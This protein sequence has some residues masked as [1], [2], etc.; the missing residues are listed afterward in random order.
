MIEKSSYSSS[1]S[2]DLSARWNYDVFLSFR[3]EDVR[4]TFVD[5]LYVALQ[6]KGIH[7]FKDDEKLEKGKS[8]GPDLIRAIEE[9]RIALIVFSKNYADSKWCLDEVV[10]IMECKNV[11]G[12]IVLPVFYDVD[13]MTVRKQKTSYGEAFSNHEARFKGSK[14]Q[15]WRAALEEAADLSGLDLSNTANAHEARFVKE[16]VEDIM[17]K[18]GSQRHA[19]NVKNLVGME[20]QMQ[21]VYKMLGVGSGGVHFVGILGMSGVGKTTL[22]RVIYDD[23]SSQFEGACFLH[24][25]RD[26]SAKQGLERLQEILLSEILFIKDL[27]INNVFEGVNMQKHRLRYKKVL[28]VLDDVDHIDHLDV[29]AG[30]REWFGP[31]SRIIITTKDKHLLVKH[32]VEK[33]YKMRTLNEEES[34]QLFKQY[35]FKKNRPTKKFERI[36]AEVIKYTAGLPLALK[37]LGSF[38]Y[39]R[40]L[41]EWRSEVE[42]LKQIPEDEIL[43]K[44]EPSF[45]GLNSNE[46]KIF[47]DIACFFTGKKKDSVTRILKSFEFSP[48]I[49]VKVLMEKSLISISEGRIIMHQLIQEMGWY[50]VRREASDYP[51]EYSRL[52]KSEDIS[53]ILARNMGT[54]KIE[55]ISL[56]LAKMYTDIS[57][58]LERNLGTNTIKGMSLNFTNVKEVN[59]SVTAFMQMTRLRFLKI[60]N[61]YVS[62][63]PDILPGELSWLS[64]HG[65]ASK[66]LPIN[67]QGERLVSLKLK[68]SR[69]IQLWKGSKVL[70]KLKYINLS[71]SHKLIRTPDFSGTPNLER[72]VLEECTSLIEINFSVGDLKK[73]LLLNL[74]NCVNLKSLPKSIGLENLEVLILSGCSKLKVFPEIEEEMNCLSELYL[75]ATALSEVPA[76]V[77][78]LSGVNLINL[79]SCKN[80]ESLP[81]SIVRLNCLKTL[82]VSKCSKLKKLPDELGL[83]VGLEGLHCD[84]T[85]IEMMPSTISLLKNLKHLTLRRCNALASQREDLGLAFSNLS[86]LCSLTML[87]IGNCSISD[88]GILCNLGFLPSL[89]ELNLGGNTFTNISAASISGLTRLKVLQLVGCSRL[90]HFPELPGAIEEVHA[91]ECTSLRSINQLAKYPTL[92]RLS[93]SECHQFHDASL[94][95]ALW[96]NMLKGL[97]VLRSDISICIPGSEIPKWFPNTKLGDNVTLTLPNNWY[98]DNFWGF[99]FCIVFEGMEWCALYDGYLQPSQGFSVMLKFKTSDGKEGSTRSVVGIKGGDTSIRNSD[100]TLLA[101]VPSR[102]FLTAYNHEDYC[103]NDWIEIVACST[104]LRKFENKAWGMRLVYLDDIIEAGEDVRKTFVD[105]LYVALQQKGINTFKDDEKLDRGNSISPDLLRAIEESRIA[106]IVFSKNYANSTW[107]LD[108]LTKIMECNKR[109]GQIVLPVFYDI[110][111]S[112]VRK[113]KHSYGEAFGKH[114]DRFNDDKLQ[115][116]RA[117]LEEAANLSGWDLPN[118][119][120]AHEARVIKQIVEDIMTKL[121][122]HT[123]ASSAEDLVGMELHLQKVY[124][125]LQVRSDEVRFLGI[126]GMG[127]V[128]KTTLAR[129]IYD[130]IRSQFEGACFL[131]EVGDRSSKQGLERLQE[132]L[133]SEIL[134][135]KE[136]RINNLYEGDNLQRKRLQCK[137]VLLVLDDVDHI[138]QLDA[139]AGKCELFGPGSRIIITTKDKHLLVKHEVEKIYRMKPL[140]EYES[141]RLFKQ[142]AFKKIYPAK[143]FDDLSA[144]VIKR[145]AG[146]PLA[147]KVLGSYLYGRDLAEWTSEVEWLEQIPENEILQKLERSFTKLNSVEKKLFL[148][149]ACFFTGKKKNAV[150]RILD[151][152]NFRSAI[153]IK[154]LMEKSL[155]TISEGRILM[156]QLIQEMGWHIVRREASND[157]KMYSRLWK[158]E[159]ISLVLERNLGTEKIEGISLNLTSKEQV[160]VS[161]AA[162]MQMTRLRFLKFRNA[163]VFQGPDFLPDELRWLDW[164]GYPSKSLP[165]SFQGEQLVSLKL[166]S[167]SIIQLWETYKV[168]GRLKCINLSYSQ[169]LIRT[170]D[171][172]GTPNLE[173]LVLEECTSL[174]EINFSV[175]D[176]GRLVLLNLKNCRNL[177]TLPESIQ[178]E[179]LE[180]F[181]L[182]GCFKLKSFPEIEGKMNCLTELYLGASALSELPAS[183]ENLSRVSVINLSY[184]KR[185]ESLPRSI[186]RLKFLK[187]LDVS[188]CSKLKNLPD[189]HLGYLIGLEEF[190]RTDTAIR[191]IPSSVSLLKNLKQ[192]SLRG[193]N[194]LGLQG[195]SSS[196]FSWIQEK[197]HWGED[198]RKTSVDHLYVALQLKGINT[199]KDDERLEKG[200]SISP[201][202]VRAIEESRIALI[203]FSKNYADS[204]WCLDELT[205]IME[206]NKQKEQIVL[207][208]FYDVDPSTVRKQKHS[209]GEAFGNHEDIFK[210]DDKVQKWRAALEEAANLSGWDLPNT[211]DAHEAKVINKILKDTMARLGGQRHASNAENLVGME[212]HMNKLYK[213]LGVE[214]GVVRFLGILGMSGVGSNMQKQ[215][216]RYKKVLLVL[217]EVDHTDQL[218]A[219]AGEREWFGPGSRVIIT[220]KNKHLLVKYEGTEKIEGMSLHLTTEEQVNVSHTAFVQMARLRFLKFQNAYVCQGPDFLPDELRW[221]DWHG[222]PSKRSLKYLNLGH[223]QKLI[224]TPDFSGTPNLERLVLEECTSLVEFKFSVGD[225]G[226]LVLLNLANCRNLKTLP[227]S[228]RLGKLEILILS[229]CS[230]LKTFPEIDGKMHSL[231]ELYLGATAISELPASIENLSGVSVINLSYC[232]HL[233]SLPSSIFRLKYMKTL[234]VSGC[235]KLENLPDDLGHLVGLEELHCTHTAIQKIPSSMTLLKNLKHLALRGCNA[236]GSQVSS[237]SHAQKS[238]GVN[239]QNLS[240]LSS[241]ITLYVSDCNISDGGIL[242]DLGFLQSL[243]ELNLDGNNFSNIPAASISRLTQLKVLALA[244]CRRLESFPELPP[245]IEELF[246]DECTSLMSID[247]LT[248]YPML[249]EGSYKKFDR[250]GMFVPGVEIPEWFTY[251][252]WGTDRISVALPKNWYTPTFTGFAICVVFDMITSHFIISPKHLKMFQGPVMKFTFTSHDGARSGVSFLLGRIGSEKPLGLDNTFLGYLPI[253]SVRTGYLCGDRYN[254]VRDWIQLDFGTCYKPEEAIKGLGVPLVNKYDICDPE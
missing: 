77:E 11:K 81:K 188:G 58:A 103:P 122:V 104:A 151:S 2:P 222:Y 202:L 166:K 83:L 176:L 67:F 167:S 229:G 143:D 250:F 153:G 174:V 252:N 171:F 62:Q 54:E 1:T 244:D 157:P 14:V 73:L 129:V 211:A 26:R 41:V 45:T 38:L 130:N 190:H 237:S 69:I 212:S 172:S 179:K 49:G 18:L 97:Y 209:Y 75:E 198:V 239:F 134:V 217:D 36:S 168:L 116:W 13:A 48:V 3:G 32:D 144:Q 118:T 57:Q 99:A 84:D 128:G 125:M 56:N 139:L 63:G 238:M 162:F 20:S 46:Q 23:I 197:S 50:I 146:L 251:K 65:Y 35:A 66:S 210:L 200:K 234:D 236:L 226:K 169:K 95:D 96:S 12:Q 164:H 219:L 220:T 51:R 102:H 25:V 247:Q 241:L 208:V 141:F 123:H 185:L 165:I 88:G 79:S 227:K 9:S 61:A 184:C 204:T 70:G 109:K 22:A 100:H 160:K 177:K 161:R 192:L 21:K 213:M 228:F 68:N 33:M 189:D 138:D 72:L 5:H 71:H 249:R 254:R 10:K 187:I 205:K 170:P 191:T 221:L 145:T 154:V 39:G 245:S 91:D 201:D 15:K 253:R 243:G 29:L 216:L 158:Q 87:D 16:I 152:F 113:Q 127:G 107:C 93:L 53:Q 186:Y 101:C 175:G 215:R 183:I 206:C 64:W 52:W 59:V 246:A 140:N 8:I 156:H 74:K 120:N 110:D 27:R 85:P 207:P 181:I 37:V 240:G 115:K 80:L 43:K 178:L 47:L 112:T 28:L 203:I 7:T 214:S 76:S 90:E 105:H 4:K 6:Q 78:K 136:L 114:E 98:T 199:F 31:G 131:H 173:R 135:L 106:L 30:K 17:A 44:L 89:M 155:I 82:N 124:K 149:I 235:S 159:D 223:S 86:G 180:V 232:K 248:K 34:L 94:V 119:A 194:A 148:D 108:E 137:K 132:I 225:L 40:D 126:L 242:C 193:C 147:L 60:K 92:R 195:S 230:K 42:R 224:R 163:Y 150:I 182:S 218:D 111:P 19:S 55:G 142:H 117:A 24:E 196:F 233:E 121:S 231:S 133:L